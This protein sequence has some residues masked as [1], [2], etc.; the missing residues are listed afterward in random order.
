MSGV[1][2]VGEEQQ[3]FV[4]R[5]GTAKGLDVGADHTPSRGPVN[6]KGGALV[7]GGA[8]AVVGDVDRSQGSEQAEQGKEGTGPRKNGEHSGV[9]ILRAVN[10]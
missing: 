9:I 7:H 5:I 6:R 8:A 10:W 3:H 2:V 4:V 1:V